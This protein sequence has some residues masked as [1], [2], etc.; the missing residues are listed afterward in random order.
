MTI[1]NENGSI[2][3][4]RKEALQIQLPPL[5]LINRFKTNDVAKKNDAAAPNKT[6]FTDKCLHQAFHPLYSG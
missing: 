5:T 3:K 6:A 1:S 2:N 4:Y